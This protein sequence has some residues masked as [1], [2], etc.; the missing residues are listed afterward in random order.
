MGAPLQASVSP[1]FIHAASVSQSEKNKSD[2]LISVPSSSFCG[3][4]PSGGRCS[5]WTWGS[6]LMQHGLDLQLILG[7]G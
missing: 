1:S 2:L 7:L 5:L 3:E 6:I 4:M